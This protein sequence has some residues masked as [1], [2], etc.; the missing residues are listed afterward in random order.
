MKKDLPIY[1]IKLSDDTQGVGFIS[2]VDEPAIGVDWIKLAKVTIKQEPK[3]VNSMMAKKALGTLDGSGCFGCPPNGDGTRVNGEPDGRCK[4]DSAGGGSKGGAR[5]GSKSTPKSVDRANV[6]EAKVGDVVTY[7][8]GSEGA[9]DYPDGI[10]VTSVR[11][12][13]EGKEPGTTKDGKQYETK[14]TTLTRGGEVTT[15]YRM[16]PGHLNEEDVKYIKDTNLANPITHIVRKNSD[17]TKSVVKGPGWDR[18]YGKD[19]K[20]WLVQPSGQIKQN[21]GKPVTNI[22]PY[23]L[24]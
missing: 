11:D 12:L 10:K 3:K 14:V 9:I 18:V 1:D 5:G 13:T 24:K 20:Y 6:S 23:G 17:G 21:Y 8:P 16:R 19:A 22:D 7:K 2:L 4:G 15:Q